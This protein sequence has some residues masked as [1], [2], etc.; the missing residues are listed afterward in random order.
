MQQ[1]LIASG[2]PWQTVPIPVGLYDA[3]REAYPESRPPFRARPFDVQVIGGIVLYEG[4]IAEMATGEARRSSPRSPAF[5]GCSRGTT[6][7][8]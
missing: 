2:Q 7:T 3:V 6:A 5:C 1:Q 8:S 4:R